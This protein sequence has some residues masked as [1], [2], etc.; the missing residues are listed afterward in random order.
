MQVH[1]VNN[2]VASSA[3]DPLKRFFMS[4]KNFQP[5]STLE[6]GSESKQVKAIDQWKSQF[7]VH[8]N[9]WKAS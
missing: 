5:S 3:S 6:T 7:K 1:C 4:P 9:D 8:E 2:V